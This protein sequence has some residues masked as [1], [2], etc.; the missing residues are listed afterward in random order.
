MIILL[1]TALFL[2]SVSAA[3]ALRGVGASRVRRSSQL[4]AE[5]GA[6]GFHPTQEEKQTEH[7]RLHE[8]I[9]TLAL[10]LGRRLERRLAQ[11]RVRETRVRLNSAGYYR[12]S[13]SR[14]LG[15]RALAALG[16]PL[17]LLTLGA[18]AGGVGGVFLI[19]VVAF[20][21]LAWA[22]PPILLSRRASRR[23]GQIDREVPELV[24]LLVTTVEAG[25][26]FA[27]ALQISARRVRGPLGDELRLT[28]REQG[29]GLT[30]EGAL[31]NLLERTKHSASMR[32]FVQAIVQGEMLGVSIG[33]I[34][35]D[36]AVEMRKRRRHVAEEQA[37][38]AP[39]KLLFPLV[40][41]IMPAM[42]I[43]VL[44]PT[45]YAIFHSLGS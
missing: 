19:V 11:P 29:M 8:T 22:G 28:L 7:H 14:Y 12:T 36:L 26:G 15:Y 40:F 13:V 2:L 24:D 44:G 39:V 34:L 43:V 9:A 5:V 20:T 42:L 23:I 30:L 18:L 10:R 45:A 27:A 21:G 4:L 1:V 41:L 37:Q 32:T 38:K 33:K 3:L 6:Y 31:E 25:V 35:R 16:T 17:C